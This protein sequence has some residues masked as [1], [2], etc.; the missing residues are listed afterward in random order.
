MS[1]RRS[2]LGS[3]KLIALC[4]LLSRITGL[5]RDILLNAAFGQ[6]RV[7]DAF[8][9][10]FQIPNLFRRLF[11]EGALTAVFVPTFTKTLDA[12][13]RPAAW[14]LLSRTATL[15]TLVLLALIIVIELVLL[16]LWLLCDRGEGG[17]SLVL[18]LTAL[19]LPFM[20]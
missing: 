5:L 7:A 4:T 9:F 18:A 20:L 19:M 1:E 8:N 10:G 16:A 13:G 6:G 2:V 14:R 3:A 12:D 11:G 17:N 15:L